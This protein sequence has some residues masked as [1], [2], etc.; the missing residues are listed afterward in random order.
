MNQHCIYFF[1]TLK[2]FSEEVLESLCGNENC[3]SLHQISTSVSVVTVNECPIIKR[4]PGTIHI[5][6]CYI[7]K[8][9]NVSFKLFN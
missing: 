4:Q 7:F 3:D 2:F 8:Y 1:K 6:L 9:M 5:S